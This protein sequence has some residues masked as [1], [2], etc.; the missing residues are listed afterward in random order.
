LLREIMRNQQAKFGKSYL[1]YK[2]GISPVL[3]CFSVFY[4]NL[5]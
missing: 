1:D 2:L 5:S 3:G 4:H